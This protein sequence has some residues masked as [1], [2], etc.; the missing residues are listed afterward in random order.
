MSD[1]SGRR[2]ELAAARGGETAAAAAG[3]PQ[4]T[5]TVNGR[6]WERA[7]GSPPRAKEKARGRVREK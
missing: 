2:R 1:W 6:G 3:K 5:E 7:R 4:E